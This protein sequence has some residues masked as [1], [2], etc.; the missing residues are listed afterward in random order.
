M[1]YCRLVSAYQYKNHPLEFYSL[2]EPVSLSINRLQVLSVI[3]VVKPLHLL[4]NCLFIIVMV[5]NA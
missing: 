4:V 2:I 5:F 1:I 3:R